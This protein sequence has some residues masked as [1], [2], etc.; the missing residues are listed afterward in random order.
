MYSR[1]SLSLHSLRGR[2][3][4]WMFVSQTDGSDHTDSEGFRDASEHDLQRGKNT[5]GSN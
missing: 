4:I 3:V 5:Q 1:L 2:P